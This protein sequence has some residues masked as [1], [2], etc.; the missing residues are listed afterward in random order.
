[1]FIEISYYRRITSTTYSEGNEIETKIIFADAHA[2]YDDCY[3]VNCS[4]NVQEVV[5]SLKSKDERGK[6]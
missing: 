3:S 5:V 2:Y 1:M 6:Y 4:L